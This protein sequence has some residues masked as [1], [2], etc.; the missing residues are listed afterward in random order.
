[1]RI[2]H[3]F[4]CLKIILVLGGFLGCKESDTCISDSV[5]SSPCSDGSFANIISNISNEPVF[6]GTTKIKIL[7]YNYFSSNKYYS[8]S[9]DSI[10]LKLISMKNCCSIASTIDEYSNEPVFEWENVDNRIIAVGI[11]TE[12]IKVFR[13]TIINTNSIIWTWNNSITPLS[14]IN[15][16]PRVNYKDGVPVKN[17]IIQYD[18]IPK[19]LANNRIYYWVIWAWNDSGSKVVASNAAMPFRI[20]DFSYKI[21]NIH[22]IEGQWILSEVVNSTPNTIDYSLKSISIFGDC[23]EFTCIINGSYEYKAKYVG[24]KY[25][26]VTDLLSFFKEFEIDDI[27]NL[28]F[29]PCEKKL[30]MDVIYQGIIPLKV[31]Y[32]KID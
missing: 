16:K 29:Y 15:G 22:S 19:P 25:L 27:S 5:L 4:N 21:N 26:D 23:N 8:I 1:M 20:G 28:H 31:T 9:G 10:L 24:D 30:F 7:P 3:C 14:Y 18:S 12:P 13:S 2:S 11:F 17:G 32:R 6:Q